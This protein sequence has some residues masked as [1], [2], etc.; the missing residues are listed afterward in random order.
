MVLLIGTAGVSYRSCIIFEYPAYC[1][2]RFKSWA[3]GHGQFHVTHGS[4]IAISS[5]YIEEDDKNSHM[6]NPGNLKQFANVLADELKT[7]GTLKIKVVVSTPRHGD[8]YVQLDDLH[9]QTSDE[10][11]MLKIGREAVRGSAQNS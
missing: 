8:I 6:Q 11:Y 4:G 9:N 5:R 3:G 10:S 2:I 7:V 1:C